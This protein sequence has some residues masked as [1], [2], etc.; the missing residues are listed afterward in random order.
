MTILL[1]YKWG[2]K[3][4]F[5]S[6]MIFQVICLNKVSVNE[7][8]ENWEW[9]INLVRAIQDY[10]QTSVCLKNEIQ[11]Y[12]N[13]WRIRSQNKSLLQKYDKYNMICFTALNMYDWKKTLDKVLLKTNS[14]MIDT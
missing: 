14:V 5:T 4:A 10:K 3:A 7:D 8:Y 13:I 6:E 12:S 1:L 11:Y 9:L 2:R